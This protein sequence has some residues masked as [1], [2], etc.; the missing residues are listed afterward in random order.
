MEVPQTCLD[1]VLPFLFVFAVGASA[2]SLLVGLGRSGGMSFGVSGL[3]FL[4]V[5]LSIEVCGDSY[6]FPIQTASHLCKIEDKNT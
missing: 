6:F 5:L 1:Q 3:L 4:W 2:L